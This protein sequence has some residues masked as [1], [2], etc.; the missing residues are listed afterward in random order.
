MQAG[1][2]VIIVFK[3]TKTFSFKFRDKYLFSWRSY[4]KF[5]IMAKNLLLLEIIKPAF[6]EYFQNSAYWRGADEVKYG[7]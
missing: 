7:N 5:S 2:I 3:H 6:L 4:T 1:L